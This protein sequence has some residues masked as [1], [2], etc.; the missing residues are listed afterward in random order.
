M[1]TVPGWLLAPLEYPV[2][3][4]IPLV[5][6]GELDVELLSQAAKAADVSES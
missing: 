5:L 2:G 1:R 4:D 6:W 3:G